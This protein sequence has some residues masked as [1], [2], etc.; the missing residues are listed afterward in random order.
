MGE[1][2]WGPSK[3]MNEGDFL[4]QR[5]IQISVFYS[6]FGLGSNPQYQFTLHTVLTLKRESEREKERQGERTIVR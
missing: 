6:N 5:E 3:H 2:R 4:Y 1:F